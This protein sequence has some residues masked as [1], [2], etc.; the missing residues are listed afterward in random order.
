MKS[1]NAQLFAKLNAKMRENKRKIHRTSMGR[2]SRMQASIYGKSNE[3]EGSQLAELDVSLR[4]RTEEDEDRELRNNA[5][6]GKDYKI[7]FEKIDD[8]NKE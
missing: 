1:Q 4:E 5:N 6:M 8:K 3:L 7:K 2:S